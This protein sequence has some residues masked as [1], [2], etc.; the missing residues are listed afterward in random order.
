MTEPAAVYIEV[1]PCELVE[2]AFNLANDAA[3]EQPGADQRSVV[4]ASGLALA[5][6][7]ASVA[8]STGGDR[9][10]F[11]GIMGEVFDHA[12]AAHLAS[13]VGDDATQH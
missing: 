13:L 8:A 4:I 3:A 12:I 5:F 10:G 1:D 6:A 9:E 2:L 11:L 7:T